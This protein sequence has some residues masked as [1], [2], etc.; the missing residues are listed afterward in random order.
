VQCGIAQPKNQ[1]RGHQNHMVIKMFVHES[2]MKSIYCLFNKALITLSLRNHMHCNTCRGFTLMELSVVLIIIGLVT[3]IGVSAGIGTLESAKRSQ[4]DSKL[5]VIENALMTFRIN[6]NRLPCPGNLALTH[7]DTGYGQEASGPGVCAGTNF[8]KA[9]EVVEGA[10]PTRA[11]NIP[12]DFMF[13]GW[14]RKINYAVDSNATDIEA[15][16]AIAIPESCGIQV[17]DGAGIPRSSGAIYALVSFGTNGHGG[18][19]HNGS[20]MSTGTMNADV[21]TNCHCDSRATTQD[22]NPLFVQKDV[23]EDPI[24]PERS[25]TN[26]VRYKERWQMITEEDQ[27]NFALGG[28]YRG[29]NIAV[30]FAMS[31]SGD[32]STYVY[33]MQCGKVIKQESL[34]PVAKE[35]STGVAFTHDN[36]YLL[37]FSDE[38]CVFYSIRGEEVK[39]GVTTAVPGCP[40]YDTSVQVAMSKNGFLAMTSPVAPYIHLWQKSGSSFVPLATPTP[41][42]TGPLSLMSLSANYLMLH[43][44]ASMT[45]YGRTSGSYAALAMQP[46]AVPAGVFSAAISPGESYIAVTVNGNVSGTPAPYI[47]M[48]R[49]DPVRCLRRCLM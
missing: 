46:A 29:P 7:K 15:F 25:F 11:L 22:Y 43:D 37:S 33:K 14:G 28:S 5:N 10:V 44:G 31:V 49:F 27:F 38:G 17:N 18:Y 12:D 26:L 9:G 23:F 13:D 41:A 21:L 8:G 35:V 36:R 3:A 2:L 39:E 48:W 4:T 20:R 45:V 24:S 1:A 40:A 30:G 19:L 47:K 34:D 42:P 16:N 6:N 32:D